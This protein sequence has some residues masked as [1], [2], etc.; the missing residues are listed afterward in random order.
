MNLSD[1]RC[2]FRHGILQETVRVRTERNSGRIDGSIEMGPEAVRGHLRDLENVLVCVQ[3]KDKKKKYQSHIS[4]PF[5]YIDPLI[6]TVIAK[7][8]RTPNMRINNPY[9]C[10]VCKEM[11]AENDWFYDG[12]G[13]CV[14]NARG[15]SGGSDNNNDDDDGS[16]FHRVGSASTGGD[17]KRST[18][19]CFPILYIAAPNSMSV[20]DSSSTSV[21]SAS[22]FAAN[23]GPRPV[24][25][26][27]TAS[28][29]VPMGGQWQQ[30]QE[31]PMG[32]GHL[33][34]RKS[35]EWEILGNLEHGVPYSI[36][37]RRYEGFLSK[38][39]KWSMKGWHKRYFILEDGV[40]TYGETPS[41]IAR[42]RTHGR[43]DV[44]TA[45][46]S[47]RTE[48]F[49]IDIDEEEC[50]HHIKVPNSKDFGLWLEQ[51]KQHRLYQQHQVNTA[52]P[53]FL[54]FFLYSAGDSKNE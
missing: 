32:Q 7:I 33:Q 27:S 53:F 43:I 23:S 39:R 26:A 13:A 30:Q 4:N 51:L 54:S 40:L 45:V 50:I 37:P 1:D 22:D 38:K 35:S 31:Q 24:S 36:K 25:M 20:S 6:I 3:I 34:K 12:D 18:Y 42:G 49:R 17:S 9:F 5:S 2:S 29:I 19:I 21:A 8:D 44:G 14:L 11:R 52:T 10:R 47:A 15:G 28:T 16:S 48:M 46:V 41:E